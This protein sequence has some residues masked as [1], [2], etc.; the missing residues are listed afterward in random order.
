MAYR[1]QIR[2]LKL[3]ATTVRKALAAPLR[4]WNLYYAKGDPRFAPVTSESVWTYK[5]GKA[6]LGRGSLAVVL[7]TRLE[8]IPLADPLL[9]PIDGHLPVRLELGGKPVVGAKIAYSKRAGA[10]S[11]KASRC[12]NLHVFYGNPYIVC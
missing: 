8:I 5:W 12:D 3:E 6:L 1:L 10:S 9:V 2:S 4:Y 7:H 11:N